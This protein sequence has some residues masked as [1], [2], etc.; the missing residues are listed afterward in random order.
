MAS[1]RAPAGLPT[2]ALRRRQPGG[3][4]AWPWPCPSGRRSWRRR[5]LAKC[6]PPP[7][8]RRPWCCRRR[9]ASPC[10]WRPAA[11]SSTPRRPCRTP[12]AA[13]PSGCPPE[14]PSTYYSRWHGTS[15]SSGCPALPFR[16]PCP[17]RTPSAWRA[18]RPLALPRR[19]PQ[20]SASSTAAPPAGSWRRGGSA[21]LQPRA[22]AAAAPRARPAPQGR[23]RATAPTRP[24]RAPSRRPGRTEAVGAP[25]TSSP[26]RG[27][28]GCRCPV[29]DP[30]PPA[31]PPAASSSRRA[32]CT[33]SS[34][35]CGSWAR[36]R[37]LSTWRP[38]RVRDV[39][40]FGARPPGTAA[41]PRRSRRRT[42]VGPLRAAPEGAQCE[43]PARGGLRL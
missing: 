24:G 35:T 38:G 30:R 14:R 33:D 36:R 32:G 23:A 19:W 25:P 26:W 11:P 31:R 10:L 6:S 40:P 7:P 22:C 17:R 4:R 42:A 27:A 41:A 3:P 9:S 5:T 39:P 29:A 15:A 18:G 13:G 37:P 16:T 12:A 2:R 20:T 34:R 1:S 21:L 28:L 8:P 43:S